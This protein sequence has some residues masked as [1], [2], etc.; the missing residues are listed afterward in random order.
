MY[1]NAVHSVV[2]F[3]EGCLR[4][5]ISALGRLLIMEIVPSLLPEHTPARDFLFCE[6]D[7]QHSS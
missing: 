4:E 2:R 3:T 1:I 7:S 5:F 6:T